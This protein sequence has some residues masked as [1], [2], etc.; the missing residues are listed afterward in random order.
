M[1]TYKNPKFLKI[2]KYGVFNCQSKYFL[3]I[4]IQTNFITMEFDQ[5]TKGFKITKMEIIMPTVT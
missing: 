4:S 5:I 1:L 2:L 3:K